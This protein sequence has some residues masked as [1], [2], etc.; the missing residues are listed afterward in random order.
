M[1]VLI[2]AKSIKYHEF[3][4]AG[5]CLDSYE[6]V[7]ILGSGMYEA[8]RDCDCQLDNGRN[9]EVLDILELELEK[10]KNNSAQTEN[11]KCLSHKAKYCGKYQVTDLQDIYQKLHK[12]Q[13]FLQNLK[14]NNYLSREQYEIMT[15]SLELI[16]VD[17]FDVQKG[18][19]SFSF[20]GQHYSHMSVTDTCFKY[21]DIKNVH[22]YLLISL[23]GEDQFTKEKNRFY[24]FI[25]SVLI[26]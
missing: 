16:E 14:G 22:A 20:Q 2:L 18:K 1:K 25:A 17:H 24:V 26:L 5:I 6:Y 13:S 23:S 21:H 19:C 7:R 12:G 9:I 8:F 3:C 15:H 11:Y 10:V 4:L